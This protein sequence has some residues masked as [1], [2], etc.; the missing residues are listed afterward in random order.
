MAVSTVQAI[1]NGTTYML[2]LN[3]TT[4]LYEA[5]ITAPSTSSYNVNTGHYYPVTIKATDDA[6][7]SATVDDSDSV[8]GSSLQ[9]FVKETT[10]PI[11]TVTSP[12]EG[13]I[14]NSNKP[15][16]YWQVTDN[17]SGVNSD[18]IG[19]TID[20]G[21]KITSGITKTV[22]T[23]GYQ[24]SYA[25]STALTDGSHTIKFDASD[26]DG[27]AATQRTLN[28][29]VDTV[30][31]TLSVTSPANN[32]ITNQSNVTVSGTTSDVTS[33]PVTLTVKLNN[34]AATSVTVGTNGEFGTSVT[35]ES[36]VNTIVI[37]ATDASG[38]TSSVTRTV[39]LDTNAPVISN[40][41]IS[42]NPVS[43]GAIVHVAV[44]VTD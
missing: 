7:N 9:L 32:L 10:K 37:T 18:T 6:G 27:N 14:T 30:P 35:L 44:S 21:S 16:I 38:K 1:I 4:G 2:T 36:G 25:I 22:I 24:C 20:E 11:I 13:H 40:I 31:P 39:T 26:Y 3:S 33:N 41:E 5:D 42:P 12:T 34:G 19:I 29:S 8:L 23:G 28:F 43:T 17:D 15:T